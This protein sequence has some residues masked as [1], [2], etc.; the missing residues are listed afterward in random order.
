[1][2][3]SKKKATALS[4]QRAAIEIFV[5]FLPVY[6][7]FKKNEIISINFVLITHDC[8]KNIPRA[9]RKQESP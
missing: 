4:F 7:F 2:P 1:M 6:S 3:K 9:Q 5:H 8:E